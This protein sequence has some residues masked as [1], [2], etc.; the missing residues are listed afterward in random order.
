[1]KFGKRLFEG[2]DPFIFVH[3]GVSYLYCTTENSRPLEAA[4]AFDTDVDGRDGIYVYRLSEHGEWE[5][6]GLCL[7][8]RDAVGERW[9][10]APEVYFYKGRF[11]M[12]FSSEEYPEIAV[13][14][15]PTGPFKSLTG[16]RLRSEKS[17]DGHLLFDGDKVYLYYVRLDCGN[18]IFVAEMSDDL[19]HITVEYDEPLIVASDPWETVDCSVAEGPFVLKHDGYYYLVYSANHTR[20]P[21]YAVGYACSESPTGP[22]VKYDGN[23]II[24]ASGDVVGVGHNSFA[25]M[26]DGSLVCAYHCHSKNPDNFKPR[27]V[28]L[29]GAEF[30]KNDNGAARLIV[31]YQNEVCE[32]ETK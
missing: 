8:G 19:T 30:V 5:R 11:Y 23:P 25:T 21:M 9:F 10:W 2:G 32:N 16:K 7:D 18:R 22:F 15:S 26:P 29:A 1:M 28:C 12:L 13:A 14:D 24:K 3:D 6:V 31:H 4:N 20:S 27:M 17:I